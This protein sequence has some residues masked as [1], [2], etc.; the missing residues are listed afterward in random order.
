MPYV[1]GVLNDV[2][3]SY[4]RLDDAAAADQQGCVS[5]F[6]ADL[7]RVLKRHV[8]LGSDEE[9]KIFFDR[10]DLSS[11]EHLDVLKEN[12]RQSAAFV[13]IISPSYVKRD[14]TRAEL[15]AFRDNGDS[16]G[17]VFAIESLPLD[18][19]ETY[20]EPFH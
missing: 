7:E 11:N 12:A 15:A 2:F 18:K 9:L 8:G 13:A 19:T 17:R 4:A 6:V 20:P 14:W 5:R 3:I 1:P 10:R 16:D